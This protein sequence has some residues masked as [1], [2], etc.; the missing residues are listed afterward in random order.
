MKRVLML[1]LALTV[2]ALATTDAKPARKP[3]EPAPPDNVL[4]IAG[5]YDLFFA[6]NPKSVSGC[7]LTIT[8]QVG[9]TFKIGIAEPT[10]NKGFDWWGEG[11]INGRKGYYDWWFPD[12]KKGR[13]TFTIDEKGQLHGQVRGSNIDWDYL[14]RRRAD[15][16]P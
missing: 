11:V 4:Q 13:T 16:A 15:K 5:T 1:S 14:G 9:N 12:G 2:I 10:G 6:N 8:S 3:G 7:V